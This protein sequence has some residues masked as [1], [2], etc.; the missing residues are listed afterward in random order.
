MVEINNLTRFKFDKKRLEKLAEKVLNGE[1]KN[2]VELSVVFVEQEE[3]RKLNKKYRKINRPTDVLSFGYKE[4]GEVVIC[5]ENVKQNAEEYG[6]TFKRELARVL[7]HGLLHILGYN[8]EQKESEAVK[9]EK[10]TNYYL[11]LL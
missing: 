11:K 1:K 3:I 5:P 7:I 4:S 9:M 6:E 2:K 8:H 10:K